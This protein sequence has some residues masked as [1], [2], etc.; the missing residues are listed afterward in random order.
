M[1]SSVDDFSLKKITFDRAVT[2]FNYDS[3]KYRYRDFQKSFSTVKSMKIYLNQV[4]A[5][6]NTTPFDPGDSGR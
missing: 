4:A 2:T 1:P 3:T 5:P 6:V